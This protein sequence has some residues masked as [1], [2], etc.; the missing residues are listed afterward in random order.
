MTAC[1]SRSPVAIR[2]ETFVIDDHPITMA[3]GQLGA[4]EQAAGA[5][6]LQHVG[7]AAHW[8]TQ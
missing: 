5:E 7:P 3:Y 6:R 1:R 8:A 2:R 4:V